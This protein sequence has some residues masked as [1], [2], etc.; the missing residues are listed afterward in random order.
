MYFLALLLSAATSGAFVDTDAAN[1]RYLDCISLVDTDV[2]KGR[3]AAQ[4]WASSGGGADAQH[5]L[6]VADI[7]AGFPKLGALRLEQIAQRKDAGDD[8]VRARLLAQAADAWLQSDET[9][10]AQ[11][12]INEA[13]LLV[14]DSGELQLTAAKIHAAREEWHQVISSVTLAEQAGFVAAYSYVLRARALTEL[15]DYETAAQDVVNALSLDPVN[16]D[17][18]VLRGELQQ[19]GI[20]IEV[21]FE[22]GDESE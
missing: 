2:K 15:G 20:V 7:T 18:L 1:E 13:I 19:T 14:P 11:D 16:V 12:A 22:S 5:C 4:Q 3:F 9:I 8:Y 6:A 10:P 17:A 21:Y